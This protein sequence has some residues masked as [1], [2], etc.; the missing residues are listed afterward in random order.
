M[1]LGKMLAGRSPAPGRSGYGSGLPRQRSGAPAV[2]RRSAT[3]AA[4]A[5]T[6]AGRS[7]GTVDPQQSRTAASLGM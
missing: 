4:T 7:P 2:A 5:A 6:A 1:D 3:T